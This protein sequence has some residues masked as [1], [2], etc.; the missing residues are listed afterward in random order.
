[1]PRPTR[2][3]RLRGC[4]GCLRRCCYPAESRHLDGT[5][6][7]RGRA[8]TQLPEVIEAPRP[9]GS[10]RADGKTVRVAGS[11]PGDAAESRH[12]DGG[13][14]VRCGAIAQLAIVIA[15][16][17]PDCAVSSESQVVADACGDR[18]DPAETRHLGQ[19]E[20]RP[21]R[22]DGA[23]GSQ[24]QTVRPTGADRGGP[25]RRRDLH[26][27]GASDGRAVTQLADSVKAPRQRPAGGQRSGGGG[28][29]DGL[30]W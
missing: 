16:P 5:G 6:P 27:A 1:M 26:R 3:H 28:C 9:D 8:V 24:C 17:G 19:T 30:C 25:V 15:P 13:G 29:S 2:P 10:A 11:D 23:T 18:G 14:P 12:L 7:R 22:P 21:R 4:V 20:V